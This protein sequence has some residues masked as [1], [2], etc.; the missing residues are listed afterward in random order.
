MMDQHETTTRA[1]ETRGSLIRWARFYDVVTGVLTLGREGA[2]RRLTIEAAA[3][4]PGERV[5]DVG[6]G[7]GTL[8]L[9]A[10][11]AAGDSGSVVGIDGSPEMIAVA[12]EK[13]AKANAQVEFKVA[14]IE[15][16]PFGDQEFD[17]VLSSFMLHHLPDDVK[18]AGFAEIRR[19][20]KPDGRLV[21]VD[22]SGASAGL[23]GLFFRLIGHHLPA[24][25]GRQLSTLMEQSG[26]R[27][28]AV[29]S[30]RRELV[31]LRAAPAS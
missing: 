12:R 19:V 10:K 22:L 14:L 17:V 4:A 5:L 1:P 7:T 27:A 16:I 6:C 30:D 13:A 20:L 21:A 9:L 31:I 24:D 11:Q 23:P 15:Q 18:L 26:L 29:P 25:Y 28:D 2:Y 8:S 3:I